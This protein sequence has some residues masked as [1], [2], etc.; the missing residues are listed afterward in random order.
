MKID[1]SLIKKAFGVAFISLVFVGCQNMDRP[2]LGD[3]PQ[4]ANAPGGPLK[5][6]VAF[7]GKTDNSLMNAVDS[8]RAKFPT[9]NP[10]E[11][12]EGISGNALKGGKAK[13]FVSYSKPNDFIAN[14]AS[15]TIA[16]WS[17]HGPPT[18]TEF[19]FSVVSD[20]WAKANMFCLFEGSVTNPIVKFFVD[21]QPGDKWFE[22]LNSERLNG[23]YDGQ[24]HHLAF[25]YDGTKSGMTAYKD[26]VA[27]ATKVWTNHGNLKMK[28]DKVLGFR[29]GGAGNPA[30]GWMNSWTGDLDQFRMYGKVLTIAEINE[31]YTKKK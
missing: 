4:D 3:Y 29:I 10:L 6:F 26:G 14:S 15:F 7:D 11:S 22:W 12:T 21:E 23:I 27:F 28:E 9:N 5:F 31:L 8:I 2:E 19:V 24:W 30:E 25:V 16:F 1:K 20:N 18:Q 13:Q 17:K